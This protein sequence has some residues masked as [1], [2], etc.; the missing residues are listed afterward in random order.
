MD[1]DN[2]F[3]LLNLEKKTRNRINPEVNI[4][5]KKKYMRNYYLNKI[6]YIP[7]GK[8]RGRPR[9]TPKEEKPDII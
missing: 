2:M 8:P 6:K 9:R 7:N 1:P 4:Y 5:K 3:L